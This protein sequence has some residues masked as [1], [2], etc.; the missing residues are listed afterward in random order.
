M[1]NIPPDRSSQS[2][3]RSVASQSTG[4]EKDTHACCCFYTDSKCY[5]RC[6]PAIFLF[7]AITDYPLPLPK[8]KKPGQHRDWGLMPILVV[9]GIAGF[10]Y[11]GYLIRINLVLVRIGSRVQAIIYL[12]FFNLWFVM[13]LVSYARIVSHTPGHP[14]APPV[15]TD[16][17]SN[18]D[19]QDE[20]DTSAITPVSWG[21]ETANV[22][23]SI[24]GGPK[25]CEICQVW[26]PDR[27]HHCRV[28][29]RCV[30]KMDHHCPWV[31]GCVGLENYRYFIQFICYTSGMA[32]WT[33]ITTL[34]AFIMF[35]SMSTFDGVALAI[36][37]ISGIVMFFIGIFTC[38]HLWLVMIN[39]TTLENIQY[40]EWTEAQK[41]S[42]KSIRPLN[43][44]TATGRN[45]FF[46]TM[47][48]NWIEVMGDQ[49]WLWF[50]PLPS[51]PLAAQDG[52]HFGYNKDVHAEYLCEKRT[53]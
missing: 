21:G 16:C 46:Q 6:W 48:A 34:A 50:L 42:D 17:P 40:R 7:S 11:Y 18:P 41:K 31:N 4:G 2:C 1:P 43:T 35:N 19:S 8:G 27:T 26:K 36:L 20:S 45:I 53:K 38:S 32:A 15:P 37:I 44:F 33:F 23:A 47:S 12:V 14:K 49:W 30:L 24:L 28:C 39:R 5:A 29:D 22:P 9:L 52:I 3:S 51:K 13:F 25:W 10:V